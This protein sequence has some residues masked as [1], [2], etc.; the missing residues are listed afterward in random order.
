MTIKINNHEI[1]EGCPTYVIAEISS[2][3]K[4]ELQ[5]AINLIED[6]SDAGAN[7]VKFQVYTPDLITHRGASI[8]SMHIEDLYEYYK[9]SYMPWEWLPIL[10]DE[11][12]ANNIDFIATPFDKGSADMLENLNI[13]AFK[14]ASFEI[15]DLALI[16]HVSLKKTPIIISTGMASI[17]EI[18]EVIH[19]AFNTGNDQLAL[20]K[21]T[22]KYPADPEDM[23][24]STISDMI[25]RYKLPIGLSDHSL[26]IRTVP[27]LAVAAGASIIE[28][29]FTSSRDG[30][31]SDDGHSIDKIELLTMIKHIREA[32]C[33]M[34]DIKYGPSE[35]EKD[36][37]NLRRSIY[38]V[39][40]I[41]KDQEFNHKNIASLRPSYSGI[42]AEHYK[43]II[44][45]KSNMDIAVNTPIEWHM[46]DKSK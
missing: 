9:E 45:K 18:N 6:A 7:A 40:N 23:N 14:I 16:E 1:G 42:S 37:Y 2:N 13:H 29:H 41:H 31:S 35:C 43:E 17:N 8:S 39:D 46:I 10:S 21:C 30:G 33:I 12:D 11:C 26:S 19:T 3:H 27:M 28:K 5:T 32:E 22:S 4:Q 38:A 24:L 15:T 44:G 20:L 34:G 36:M 25:K